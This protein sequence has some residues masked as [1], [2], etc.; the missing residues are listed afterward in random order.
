LIKLNSTVKESST[1]YCLPPG[2]GTVFPY[3]PLAHALNGSHSVCALLNRAFVDQGGHYKTWD[4]M[5][6]FYLKE[7]RDSQ[8]EG[9]YKLLGWSTGGAIAWDISQR[10]E[11]AVETVEWL[12]LIDPTLPTELAHFYTPTHG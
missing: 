11:A 2:G 4:E 12:G 6:V 3:Y 1:I 8:P 9:P 5:D 10:L 7:I